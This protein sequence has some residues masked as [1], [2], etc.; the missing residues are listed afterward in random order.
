VVIEDDS[1]GDIASTP[2]VS[3]G[4]W[5]PDQTVHIRSFAKSHG[6]DL[7]IAAVGGPASVL[8]GLV[9][10]RMLGPGWTSRML[11]VV[12]T[13]LLTDPVA[14]GAVTE[15][16]RVYYARQRALTDALRRHGLDQPTADGINLWMPV[17]DERAAITRLEAV[18]IRVAPGAPFRSAGDGARPRVRVT[19]GMVRT[20][21]D[22][23]GRELALAARGG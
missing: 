7:R 19:V 18:G 14:I 11:Q 3:L 1:A 2:A 23:V 16:R 22:E 10:R 8:D 5:L 17:A 13:D 6:P 9:A 21:F 12:L 4:Q 15:A 20:D